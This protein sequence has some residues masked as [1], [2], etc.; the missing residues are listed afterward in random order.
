M[1]V[2]GFHL[3]LII[4]ITPMLGG[5]KRNPNAEVGKQL[6]ASFQTAEPE[7]KQAAQTLSTSL[8][9]NNYAEA[10][11][12]IDPIVARGE[13]TQQQKIALSSALTR[14]NNAVAANPALDTKEMYDLRA[15]MT[16]ALTT[17]SRF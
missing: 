10:A 1:K 3:L 6:Q 4:A 11:R 17:K 9:A 7:I 13:L 15:K 8:A 5:C 16:Q 2:S 14:M 12:A